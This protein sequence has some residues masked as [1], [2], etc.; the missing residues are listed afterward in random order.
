MSKKKIKIKANCPSFLNKSKINRTYIHPNRKSKLT[1]LHRGFYN[2]TF[3]NGVSAA[4]TK[5]RVALMK[6]FF[7]EKQRALMERL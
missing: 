1:D 4:D 3:T 5:S 2:K 7:F 6:L